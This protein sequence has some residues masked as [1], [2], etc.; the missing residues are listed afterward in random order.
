M[1]FDRLGEDACY[2]SD[3]NDPNAIAVL[4]IVELQFDR[5]KRV[6]TNSKCFGWAILNA[7][8]P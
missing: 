2:Y 3:L 6:A 1:V 8:K 7:F 4:E 5:A